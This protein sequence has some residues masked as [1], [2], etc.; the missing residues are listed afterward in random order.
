MKIWGRVNSTNV[1]KVRWCAEE[2]GIDYEHIDAGGSF[3][4][5]GDPDYLAMNPNGL[6]P[7]LKDGDLILWES[8]A[9]VRYLARRYGTEPFAS[10]DAGAW[11]SAD[12]W[13]D[14][15]S[16]SFA[17]P[18]RD[19]FWNLVRCRPDQRNECEMK[20]GEEQ[21]VRLMTIADKALSDA[22]YLSGVELGIG[23]V[24]LGAIAYAWFSLPIERPELTY[25]HA[26]YER[27][28]LRPA[29][30]KAVMTPL[31]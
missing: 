8:N 25:L 19:L 20:R 13:M 3:G 24:P 1:R 11:A 17:T 28:C 29:F 31:T 12:K 6:V 18:F 2:I 21:C 23:D 30:Q 26:W 4:M 15:A 9:I 14:W 10:A 16:L 27:L 5:V 22:P 7:C